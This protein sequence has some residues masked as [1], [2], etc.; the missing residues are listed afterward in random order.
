MRTA[1]YDRD[2]VLRQAMAVFAQKGYAATSMQ[3]L[4][5]ATGLHPGSLYCAFQNKRGI[6]LAALAR[7][8]DDQAERHARLLSQAE[9]PIDSLRRLLLATADDCAQSD[10][11]SSCLV[12]KTLQELAKQDA[13]VQEVLCRMNTRLEARL[14]KLLSAAQQAGQLDADTPPEALAR[15][16]TVGLYGLR[17]YAQIRPGKEALIDVAERI[18]ASLPS[19]AA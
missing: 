1:E 2:D 9:T 5:A 14:T 13:E 19:R 3:D 7:Y 17:T 15:L 11:R 12:T 6:L 10:A 18:L 16:L 8:S 4:V